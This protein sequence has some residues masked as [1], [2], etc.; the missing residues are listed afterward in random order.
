MRTLWHEGTGVLSD[1][2]PEHTEET[3]HITVAKAI[4]VLFDSGTNILEFYLK[5][6]LLGRRAGDGELLLS[7][8]RNL[9]EA[10]IKNSRAMTELCALCPSLGFHSE[11]EGYKFFPE[12]IEDRIKQLKILLITEFSA[13]EKRIREGKSPLGY[14]DGEE[15]HPTL[16]KYHMPEGTIS[17]APWESIGES[18]SHRFRMAYRGKKLFL[19]LVSEDDDA[20]FLVS[21]EFRLTKPDVNMRFDK[22]GF[23]FFSSTEYMF[24]QMLRERADEELFKWRNTEVLTDGGVHLRFALDIDELGLDRIRP[25]KMRF[26]V[27][28][29]EKWCTG[30]RPAGADIMP[31]VTLGKYD[32]IPDEF[33]WII[34]V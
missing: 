3:E 33:G 16:K 24:N 2:V 17:D 4:D 26:V 21:P 25:M 27:N 31:M 32:T 22:N 34:P 14:Y 29:T 11:A 30:S 20:M 10:E 13:V 23:A 6:D 18:G 9:I 7:E 12:K 1:I 28:D 8:M 19:E 5:R 15:E